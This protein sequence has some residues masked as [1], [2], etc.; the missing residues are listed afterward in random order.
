MKLH[1]PEE[2]QVLLKDKKERSWDE[3]EKA[4]KSVKD[5]IDNNY[6]KTEEFNYNG[7]VLYTVETAIFFNL[8]CEIPSIDIE[9]EE[10]HKAFLQEAFPQTMP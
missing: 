10:V 7:S 9:F 1:T 8:V 2:Y 5:F 4:K 3:Y 6:S